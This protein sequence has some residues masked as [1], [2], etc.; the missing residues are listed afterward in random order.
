[1]CLQNTFKRVKKKFENIEKKRK[2]EDQK[3]I[4]Y[5]NRIIVDSK[6]GRFFSSIDLFNLGFVFDISFW[7]VYDFNTFFLKFILKRE[8]ISIETL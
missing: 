4:Y 2:N 6:L 3:Y 5:F 7:F 1:M 8:K